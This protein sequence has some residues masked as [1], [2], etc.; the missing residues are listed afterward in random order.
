MTRL[1]LTVPEAAE[2]CGVSEK[3]IRAAIAKGDLRAKRQS[4]N[5]DG[6]GVG[7]FLIRVSALEDWL[8]GLVDA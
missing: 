3:I 2:S 1:A 4:K 8:E 5:D 6:D 7:K